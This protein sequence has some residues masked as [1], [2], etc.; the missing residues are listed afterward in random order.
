MTY[1]GDKKESLALNKIT[2]TEQTEHLQ[3]T[4]LEIWNVPS[5]WG[6]GCGLR[7]TLRFVLGVLSRGTKQPQRWSLIAANNNAVTQR[8][9]F[10][11]FN[12]G[13]GRW[14]CCVKFP[15]T[16]GNVCASYYNVKVCAHRPLPFV[17]AS[18]VIPTASVV[19]VRKQQW[20]VGVCNRN[21]FFFSVQ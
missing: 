18:R 14:T 15:S 12:K 20:P 10:H 19:F 2:E 9:R 1:F 17:C 5:D 11:F 6:E 8:W 4:W 13:V 16:T 21:C 7:Q 3:D